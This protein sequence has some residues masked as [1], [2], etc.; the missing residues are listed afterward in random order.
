MGGKPATRKR[1]GME[2][3]IPDVPVK[4]LQR[5][6]VFVG[7]DMHKVFLQAVAVDADGALLLLFNGRV[8]NNRG[9]IH[10]VRT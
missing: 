8:A 2:P 10:Q 9:S 1:A 6:G 7:I 4:D 3:C 5:G